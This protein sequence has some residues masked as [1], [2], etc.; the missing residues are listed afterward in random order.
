MER[1]MIYTL[2]MTF[3][4][5]ISITVPLIGGNT[6]AETAPK[7]D[8]P[9]DD[10]PLWE[11]KF[12]DDIDVIPVYDDIYVTLLNEN[13][14]H[15]LKEN[16]DIRWTHEYQGHMI[17]WPVVGNEHYYFLIGTN[18]EN[19]ITLRSIDY[20]TGDIRWETDIPEKEIVWTVVNIYEE[21]YLVSRDR[22]IMVNSEGS[23]R[24]EREIG[25]IHN[26]VHKFMTNKEG[27]LHGVYRNDDLIF[28]SRDGEIK[29]TYPLDG[30]DTYLPDINRPEHHDHIYIV[31]N[32]KI[33]WLDMS[34]EVVRTEN[35]P[36]LGDVSSLDIIHDTFFVLSTAQEGL[37]IKSY[38]RE[39]VLEWERLL[40]PES[41][42]ENQVF[43]FKIL[44]N[45]QLY[46]LIYSVFL[47]NIQAYELDGT[48]RWEYELDTAEG[49]R[50][51]HVTETGTLYLA[52]I[53]GNIYAYQDRPLR[54]ETSKL[55]FFYIALIVV[56]IL[57]SIFVAMIILER[58]DK[59]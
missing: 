26:G 53:H 18:D 10:E 21:V 31:E 15:L 55:S 35:Y 11:K 49:F 1:E 32:E 2:I 12:D 50:H 56:T 17:S 13:R 28:I 5:I 46:T 37:Y 30:P 22:L 27:G 14:I 7:E 34:G 8:P 25:N 51:L 45:N 40:A 19:A 3:M 29:W 48:L 39:G 38:T 52:S 33:H 6:S 42:I 36:N 44:E 43:R 23:I 9:L 4:V 41:S 58:K 54:E 16:G 57:M 20:E 47:K 24:W 59:L